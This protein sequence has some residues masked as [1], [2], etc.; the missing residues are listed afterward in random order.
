M[1]KKTWNLIPSTESSNLN[2]RKI[3][4]QDLGEPAS[5]YSVE[6]RRLRHGLSDGVEVVTIHNGLLRIVVLP[7]RGMNIYKVWVGDEPIG[8]NSP[9][10]GP[11]HPAFVPLSEP[12]GLGWLDGFD[13]WIARCG[14]ESNGA[15]EFDPQGRLRYGLHGHISNRP[16]QHVDLSIDSESGTI[17]LT[18]IV[19]ETRFL[20]SKLRLITTITTSLREPSLEI[21][22]RVV[23]LSASPTDCQLLYHVNFGPPLL[24]PDASV[25]VPVRKLAPR[26]ARAAEDVATWDHYA[27]PEPGYAE[28]VY[29][30]ELQTDDQHLT[31]VVLKN[32]DDSRATSLIYNTQ[33]LPCF[34]LWKNTTAESDGYVTGL[35]PATNYPNPRSFEQ[36]H[37]RV[38]PLAGGE[39]CDFDL[40]FEFHQ[41]RSEVEQALKKVQELQR[42]EPE[43]HE[44]PDSAWSAG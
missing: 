9:V 24:G 42:A 34:S 19:D 25:A 32:A 4:A 29:F 6:H 38:V 28:Q 14:L 31:R 7:T 26:D 36:R 3:T 22:D 33:Q 20:F 39:E 13:E 8:W 18:G 37:C 35:E 5:D 1:T 43:I 11:V 12:S 44:L 27:A 15:P 41:D 10:P 17:T 21:H 23:N 16:A 40:R 30:A 2:L